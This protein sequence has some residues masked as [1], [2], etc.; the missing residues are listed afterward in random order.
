MAKMGLRGHAHCMKT[1][2]IVGPVARVTAALLLCAACFQ[3]GRWYQELSGAPVAHATAHVDT[4]NELVSATYRGAPEPAP[5]IIEP[6]PLASSGDPVGEPSDIITP[7]N[8]RDPSALV[9]GPGSSWNP[10]TAVLPEPEAP[11]ATEASPRPL[12]PIKPLKSGRLLEL[13]KKGEEDKKAPSP[14]SF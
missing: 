1:P 10:P 4:G 6:T 11:S 13:L 12:K 14:K 7:L 9:M 5:K 8:V 2:P 3:A